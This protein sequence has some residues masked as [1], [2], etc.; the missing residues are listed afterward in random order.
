ME[1]GDRAAVIDA[2]LDVHAGPVG[3]I[4]SL[5]PFEVTVDAA[6]PCG[7]SEAVAATA[8]AP[9]PSAGPNGAGLAAGGPGTLKVLTYNIWN[10]NAFDDGKYWSRLDKLTAQIM[11]S[12][13]LDSGLILTSSSGA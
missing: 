2:Q 3:R 13:V 9:A 12:G 7:G 4:A 5:T 11:A 10:I 6:P 1:H 8:G